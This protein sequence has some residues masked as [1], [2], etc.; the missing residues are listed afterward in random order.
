MIPRILLG[1]TLVLFLTGQ[2]CET[3]DIDLSPKAAKQCADRPD[4]DAPD[5]PAGGGSQ[6]MDVDQP[7]APVGP[8]GGPL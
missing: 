1:F 5:T 8:G 2:G 4:V 3:F 6:K 7:D